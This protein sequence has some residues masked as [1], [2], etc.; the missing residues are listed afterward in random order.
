MRAR[1][2]IVD[3]LGWNKSIAAYLQYVNAIKK[4]LPNKG[5]TPPAKDSIVILKF[6]FPFI[7]IANVIEMVSKY[8]SGSKAWT[9]LLKVAT[10]KPKTSWENEMEKHIPKSEDEQ[11][12]VL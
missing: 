1:V 3:V 12:G 5:T 11:Q 10:D 9:R 6:L 4:V 8:N 2:E 7:K